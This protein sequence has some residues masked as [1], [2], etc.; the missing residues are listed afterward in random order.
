MSLELTRRKF[1][2]FLGGL[3]VSSS[4]TSFLSAAPKKAP[5]NGHDVIT[6]LEGP[7][8]EDTLKLAPGFDV[9]FVAT[10]GDRINLRGDTFGISNDFTGFLP[11]NAA[12]KNDG[13]LL[14]N[15]EFPE[16]LLTSDGLAPKDKT[17]AHIDSERYS[18]GCSVVRFTK[19]AKTKRWGINR[20]DPKNRRLTAA[21]PIPFSADEKIG[22]STK[23]IGTFANCSGGITPW[24]T[25]LT[26][27]ENFADYFG[28]S[29]E[30]IA[31]GKLKL[32]YGWE[33]F[34]KMAP[35]H[36]GWVVEVNP[37]TAEEQKLISLGRFAHEGALVVSAKSGTPV[38]YMGDDAE[39][40]CVYKFVSSSKT[41]LVKGT[42]YVANFDQRRWVPL[43]MDDARLKNAF[44]TQTEVM[45]NARDAARK[46]G[47]T[48]LDRPEG[49]AQNPLT[50]DILISLT[51][52]EP[53]GNLHGSLLTIKEKDADPLALTFDYSTFSA[54]GTASG[55]SC[56]DN[57]CFDAKGGLWMTTDISAKEIRKDHYKAFGNNA[58]FYIPTTGPYAGTPYKIASAPV[59]AELTGPCVLPDRE[60][61]LLSVQH[62]GEYSPSP[63]EFSSHWPEGKNATPK[64]CVIAIT[65][66]SLKAL[67]A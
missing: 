53:R 13:Y 4:A 38:V 6:G 60:T 61:L 44:K 10:W 30:A 62:P 18:V 64:S 51:N 33:R 2:E 55:F 40:E 37:V 63:K 27:E 32:K 5:K 34:Y 54:G 46:V 14:V 11:L 28:P 66:K 35:E 49:I 41:S 3:G 21:S 8:T 20:T 25:F 50:G 48:P 65:G 43:T 56:P 31:Q 36:Y 52:N 12:Q 58:L 42:L 19:E 47:G 59:G 39:N 45:I 9:Y 17:K 1:L 16:P 29:S 23:A 24:G 22:G 26:C 67:W 7:Q 57:I 15:H